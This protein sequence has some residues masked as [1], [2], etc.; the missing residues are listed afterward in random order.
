M[1]GLD[2]GKIWKYDTRYA[3]K[4][5]ERP[6]W[7]DGTPM[8]DSELGKIDSELFEKERLVL[9]IETLATK[10]EKQ[11]IIDSISQDTKYA[12]IYLAAVG[13]YK[14]YQNCCNPFG[15]SY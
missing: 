9:S 12:C 7:A 13:I 6:R 1:I 8:Y 10:E 14:E 5:G 15:W 11:S 4:K 2:E 3:Y